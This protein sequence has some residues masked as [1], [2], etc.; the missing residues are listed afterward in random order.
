MKRYFLW[1]FKKEKKP[2]HL[3]V[4]W[5]WNLESAIEKWVYG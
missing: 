5:V 4:H 2:T 1:A 3:V